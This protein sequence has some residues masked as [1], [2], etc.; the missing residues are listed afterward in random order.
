MDLTYTTAAVERRDISSS[1]TGSG[2]LEAAN[3]YSVTALVEGSI[4]TDSF[5]EG[6]QVEEGMVLYTIDSSDSTSSL[7]QAQISLE[8]AQRNYNKQLE[9]QADLNISSPA[10]GQVVS[11][12]VEVGDEVSAGQTVATIR[13]SGTM[14]LT[15]NFPSDDAQGFY[16]GQSAVVTLDSTFETLPGTVTKISGTDTVL[17][18]NIIVRSVTI[19]VSNPGGLSTGQNAT[20]S[21]GSVTSTGSGTF[22]YRAEK[23]VTASVSGEVSQLRV[24]EGDQVT[25]GQTLVV[26]TSDDL[27]DSVQNAAESVRNAELSLENQYDRLEDYTITSQSRALW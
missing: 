22:E 19:Q 25:Q 7:E 2:T 14:S 3:S 27:N 21:V 8:Q 13:D 9:N 12:D 6:D 11:L 4:L 18:G 10:S 16:V 20:A 26:M 5:E 24:S 23:T 15:V 17:T 1:I